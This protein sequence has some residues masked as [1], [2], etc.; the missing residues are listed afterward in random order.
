MCVCVYGGERE[1]EGGRE[2]KIK[3]IWQNVSKML[4]IRESR[5]SFYNSCN[6]LLSLKLFQNKELKKKKRTGYMKDNG[7]SVEEE[8]SRKS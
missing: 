7:D 8:S 1:R 4:T 3:Q 5:H 6:F 2:G